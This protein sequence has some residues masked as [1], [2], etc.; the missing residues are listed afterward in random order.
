MKTDEFAF[1]TTTNSAAL[2]NGTNIIA[3]EVHQNAGT[4][5]DLSFELELIANTVEGL[6]FTNFAAPYVL[7]Q[8]PAA[9]ASVSSLS[10]VQV[11]FSESV[12]G[13]NA[14]DFLVN[15]V[16]ANSVSGGGASYTFNFTQP[17]NGAV[18]I[19]WAGGHGITDQEIGRASCRERVSSPV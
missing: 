19:T 15:G 7:S 17:A 10:S 9:G 2:N 5:S 12:S 18:N 11:T 13:V 14:A 8:T 3:V 1:F 4:S 6:A 16:P